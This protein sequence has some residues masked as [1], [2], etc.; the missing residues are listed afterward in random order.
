MRHVET[1]TSIQCWTSN[2]ALHAHSHCHWLH[3]MRL[4]QLWQCSS[5]HQMLVH[6][7]TPLI[8]MRV[9]YCNQSMRVLL[10]VRCEQRSVALVSTLDNCYTCGIVF[11]SMQRSSKLSWMIYCSSVDP[12]HP[13]CC[14]QTGS[15][16]CV[17]TLQQA[18]PR[19]TL[20][21]SV[22]RSMQKKPPN[23]HTFGQ[24]RPQGQPCSSSVGADCLSSMPASSSSP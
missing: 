15:L 19:V 12:V 23:I 8:R 5:C 21:A 13:S 4:L 9:R 10:A 2:A 18:H 16:P 3:W 20:A 22:Q 7:V 24:K 17:C 6:V 1:G 11:P 14:S